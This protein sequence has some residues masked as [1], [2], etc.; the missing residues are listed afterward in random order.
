MQ[1][2]LWPATVPVQVWPAGMAT[3]RGRSVFE[4]ALLRPRALPSTLVAT[5]MGV[6]LVPVPV[7]SI[8]AV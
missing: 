3:L 8:M 4:L 7:E 1:T 2:L 6:Q 5:V